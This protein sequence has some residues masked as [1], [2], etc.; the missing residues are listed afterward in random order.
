MSTGC[1]P[2]LVEARAKDRN[3]TFTLF[4]KLPAELR[5]MVWYFALPPPKVIRTR[6]LSGSTGASRA[7]IANSTKI[8]EQVER[9]PGK[10]ASSSQTLSPH[11]LSINA[12]SRQ[13]ALSHYHVVFHSVYV[14]RKPLS[15]NY[16]TDTIYF[17]SIDELV[18]FVRLETIGAIDHKYNSKIEHVILGIALGPGPIKRM[19]ELMRVFL[20][21]KTVILTT[22]DEYFQGCLPVRSEM[23]KAAWDETRTSEARNVA[24]TVLDKE[25]VKK[26]LT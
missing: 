20:N 5:C 11:L 7:S 19:A 3:L 12:E 6:T 16:T 23:F 1:G 17:P 18:L 26:M 25:S 14:F 9:D 13:V 2:A 10:V 8:D 15:I 21:L 24:F 4:S 22:P